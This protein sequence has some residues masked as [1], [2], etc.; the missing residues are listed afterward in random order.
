MIRK[1]TVLVLGAG[2]SVPYGFPTGSKLAYQVYGEIQRHDS[3]LNTLLGE[4][5][6]SY[7]HVKRHMAE[8]EASDSLSLDEFANTRPDLREFVKAAIVCQLCR[9]ENPNRL[10]PDFNNVV[11]GGSSAP[12]VDWCRYLFRSMKTARADEFV[13]NKLRVITFNFDRSFEHRLA[14]MA[15]VTYRLDDDALPLVCSSFPVLHL[16]GSLGR[17]PYFDESPSEVLRPYTPAT[18]IEQRCALVNEIKIVQDEIPPGVL[19]TARKHLEW[20]EQ[21]WFLGFGYHRMNMARLRLNEPLPRAS[22]RGSALGFTEAELVPVR[23]F[24]GPNQINLQP[25]MDA[26]T[27][28]R[29]DAEVLNAE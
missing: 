5:G 10:F 8:F 19:G 26:L 14:L 6:H 28:L 20:A 12:E 23:K 18:T 24:C 27:F 7:E 1:P 2:A 15:R 22:L 4:C 29:N 9:Q 3:E 11:R 17:H 21:I 13:K 25:L 16:H